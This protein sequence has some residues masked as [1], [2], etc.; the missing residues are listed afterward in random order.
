MFKSIRW[1]LQLWY[2]TI[3]TIALAALVGLMDFNLRRAA[4]KQIDSELQG[5]ALALLAGP[6][7]SREPEH[8]VR[9]PG[10]KPALL[11][12]PPQRFL[13]GL[14]RADSDAMDASGVG[15][16]WWEMVPPT[17][18]RR[19]QLP[20][21][22]PPYYLVW[23]ASGRIFRTTS[24]ELRV[25]SDPAAVAAIAAAIANPNQTQV[26]VRDGALEAV[27]AEAGR[28]PTRVLVGKSVRAEMAALNRLRLGVVGGAAAILM[29]GLVGGWFLTRRALRPIG[30]ISDTAR[31]ISGSNLSGRI[32]V[33]ETKSELGSL[34]RTLNDAFGRVES[35]FER[36]VRFTADASHELR[37]P[38]AV[39]HA[40]AALSLS[41]PRTPDQ[42][43]Q[44]LQ[45]CHR[46]ARRM[47]ILVESLLSLARVDSRQLPLQRTRFDLREVLDEGVELVR[48]DAAERQIRVETA[49]ASEVLINSDRT[50]VSRIVT[51]LLTNAVRYNREGGFVRVA[52]HGEGR[53]AWIEIAD[54]GLGI[55]PEDQRHIYERF[56]RADPAR[57]SA[58]GGVGLGLSMSRELVQLL[59]GT[60]S[61]TSEKDVGTI[62]VVRL[63]LAAE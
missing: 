31:A 15:D 59:G 58:A 50:H 54:S 61:F 14:P 56:F 49:Y 41:K 3:L 35:A 16:W 2:A 55:A 48:D 52:L 17:F 45:V 8:D 53:E 7:F 22:D 39:I 28:Y 42:Y 43:Q 30:E 13:A 21:G 33:A 10:E 6:D 1:T 9:E 12:L 23:T 32:P 5:A 25:P 37:T 44:T 34:A 20:G 36:Q 27:V 51:N 40:Q 26:I 18:L 4:A 60:I 19:L 57:S 38:L 11:E 46:A 29:V 47:G 63:P 62:F 24:P